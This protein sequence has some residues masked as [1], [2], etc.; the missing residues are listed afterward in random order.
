M[1]INSR[2]TYEVMFAKKKPD[3]TTYWQRMGIA[4]LSDKGRIH[5]LID[6]IPVGFDGKAIAFPEEPKTE[7]SDATRPSAYAQAVA[8]AK[9][10]VGSN[11]PRSSA[12]VT[13]AT[14]NNEQAFI[15]DD[16][17]F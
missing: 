15:D 5:M 2:L 4:Y 13:A 3:G 10:G 7:G 14:G 16:L 9:A 1:P 17:P 12:P 8:G 6:M 11:T